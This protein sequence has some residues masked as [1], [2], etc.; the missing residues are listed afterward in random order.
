M[1]RLDGDELKLRSLRSLTDS[2]SITC[3][4]LIDPNERF[5]MLGRNKAHL[6]A[7]VT[8]HPTPVVG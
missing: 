6:V 1:D 4:G 3:V 8:E 7:H 2:Q 5:N